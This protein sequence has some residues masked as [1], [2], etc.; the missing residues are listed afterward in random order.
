MALQAPVNIKANVLDENMDPTQQIDPDT[1]LPYSVQDQAM[2][3]AEM[4]IDQP[5]IDPALQEQAQNVPQ[6]QLLDLYK[7]LSVKGRE[8]LDKQNE[9]LVN[10][11]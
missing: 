9:G 3:E 2:Q 7:Q 11:E 5:E 4:P 1:G 6:N 8:A 10:N